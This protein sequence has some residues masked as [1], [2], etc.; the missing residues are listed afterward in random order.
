[1]KWEQ[2]DTNTWVRLNNEPNKYDVITLWETLPMFDDV[3][4]P[5]LINVDHHKID[6]QTN[7]EAYEK[8][9]ENDIREIDSFETHEEVEKYLLDTYE[10]KTTLTRIIGHL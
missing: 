9:I 2:I 6:A 1:M 5:Y 7:E 8:A 3:D 4:T 10:I